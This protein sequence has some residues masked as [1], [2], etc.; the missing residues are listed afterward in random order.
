MRLWTIHPRY[1]DPQG[2]VALWREALLAKAVLRGKTRGYRN[3]PQLERFRAHPSPRGAIN[4][5][6][7]AVYAEATARGYDFDRRKVGPVREVAPLPATSGQLEYEWRH[8][9]RKLAARNPPLHRRWKSTRRVSCHPQFR[10]V[11]GPIA[12]WERA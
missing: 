7:A 11:R 4:A 3:H 1:L 8:L 6:L 9:L 12:D 5:Y 2:L 10:R